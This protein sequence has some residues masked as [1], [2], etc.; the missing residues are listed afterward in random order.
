MKHLIFRLI[1]IFSITLTAQEVTTI[2]QIS[3]NYGDGMIVTPDGD[4]LVSGGYNKNTILKITPLGVVTTYITG[5]PGPVG[6]G[7]DSFG[8]LYVCNY[9]G[10]S[11][12]KITSGGV[13]SLFASNLDGPAG[14]TINDNDE[15]FVTLYGA[16]L[17]GIGSTVLKFDLLGNVQTYASGSG[18]LD[19]IGI[20]IDEGNNAYVT[21]LGG[22]NVFKIDT[23]SNISIIG[24]VTGANINQIVYSN[25]Y[26][27]IP[28]PNLRKIYRID[29]LTGTVTHI[30]GSGGNSTTDGTLLEAEFNHPNSCAI[31]ADGNTLYILEGFAGLIRAIDL[32]GILEIKDAHSSNLDLIL[33][34]NPVDDSLNV[35]GVLPEAGRYSMKVYGIS[36]KQIFS[37]DFSTEI[38]AISESIS[39][40]GW[41]KG[42]YILEISN[43]KYLVTKKFLK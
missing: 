23:N 7:F 33:Y 38:P 15:I 42:T 10:N 9:T 43:D 19:V 20:T 12:S 28:S 34:P 21:N 32:T 26:V 41:Y 8:N 35:K 5:L 13:V 4:I 2:A 14:L 36:G 6:M 11:I 27:Y 30:A 29:T 37:K 25:S 22:G 17:S 31:S 3:T 40:S 24:N 1:F 18:L 39:I 16:G